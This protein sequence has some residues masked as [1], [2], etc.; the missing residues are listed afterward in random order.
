MSAEQRSESDFLG[1]VD[2]PASALYG[3]HTAVRWRIS[4]LTGRPVHPELIRAYGVVKL[5]CLQTNRV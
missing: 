3:V 4:P 1:A 2:L 5:A